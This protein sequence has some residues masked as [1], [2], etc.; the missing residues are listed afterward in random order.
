M[1]PFD[2]ARGFLPFA[3][4]VL[5]LVGPGCSDDDDGGSPTGGGADPDPVVL[6]LGDGRS[7]THV[8]ATLSAAGFEVRDGGLF[9]EYTGAGLDEADAVVLL[10]GYDDNHDMQDAGETALVAFVS[11]GGGL[12]TTE[13]LG[14]SIDRSDD[15]QILDP[16]LPVGYGGTY[17]T[18]AE[19]LSVLVD[20][21][22]TENLP[23]SFST[24]SANQYSVV[25]PRS[26]ATQLVRGSRSGAAVVTWTKG[27]RVVSLNMAGEYGGTGVWNADLE[28]LV[29]DATGFAA[30]R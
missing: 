23:A 24:E 9:H 2:R 14:Y 3:L 22:V 18:G 10:A 7:E 11:A 6:V 27:G 20:H 16:I 26:G 21:P 8:S 28:R 12:V 29:V 4:A 13:W 1:K 30:H 5:L 25:A 17:G 19:T 15:H